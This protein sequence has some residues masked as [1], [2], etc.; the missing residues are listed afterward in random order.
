[1]TAQEHQLMNHDD[2]ERRIADLERGQAAQWAPPQPDFG[3]PWEPQ[4]P[5]PYVSDN[6][7]PPPPAS[8]FGRR[9]WGRW[10]WL[11]IAA[12]SGLAL[13]WIGLGV[14]EILA[15]R[16]GTPAVATIVKCDTQPWGGQ[17]SCDVRWY[18]AERAHT[19][20]LHRVNGRPLTGS[21]VDVRVKGDDAYAAT[22]GR[23]DWQT[24]VAGLG[25]MPFLYALFLLERKFER[26]RA[27]LD[28]L[29]A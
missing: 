17:S 26:R 9:P 24:G 19:G 16:S 28:G 3:R 18:D 2:P 23:K 15:Y 13:F 7:D 4:P 10:W 6:V 11:A 29:V 27:R 20:R 14:H 22:S 1:M 21:L 8:Y 5:P 12:W 25:M